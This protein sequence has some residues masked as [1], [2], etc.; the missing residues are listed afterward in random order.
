MNGM[1]HLNRP[2]VSKVNLCNLVI[3]T[4]TVSAS[5]AQAR[6]LDPSGNTDFALYVPNSCK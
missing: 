5:Q 4:T 1:H 2:L 6:V 3:V